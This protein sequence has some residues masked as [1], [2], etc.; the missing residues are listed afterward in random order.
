MDTVEME[1]KIKMSVTKGA[2]SEIKQLEHHADYILD[3]NSYPEI[4]SIYDA[5]VTLLSE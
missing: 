2:E 1:F 3:L 4:Q 5:E